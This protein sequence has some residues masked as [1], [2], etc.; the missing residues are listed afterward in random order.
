[1]VHRDLKPANVKV[2][3]DGTVKVLDFGLAKSVDST[4]HEIGAT[5]AT[6]TAASS[7]GAVLGT[8]AYMSPEQARGHATDSTSRRQG[9]SCIEPAGSL[10]RANRFGSIE[11]AARSAPSVS[12]ATIKLRAFPRTAPGWSSRST[13][14]A[15]AR[16]I[17]GS[18]T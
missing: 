14:C 6:I 8:A 11:A 3:P 12:P 1:M 9:R 13:T 15:R 5:D 18:S 4:E 16:E 2:R 7:L 17:S 10:R